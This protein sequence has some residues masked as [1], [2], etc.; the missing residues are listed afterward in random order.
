MDGFQSSFGAG[1]DKRPRSIK[2]VPD[3]LTIVAF[4]A[5]LDD[6]VAKRRSHC[7]CFTSQG[8]DYQ[9]LILRLEA[10]CRAPSAASLLL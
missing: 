1:G 4:T 6:E 9:S 3:A 2:A 10:G 7:D 5:Q 8:T